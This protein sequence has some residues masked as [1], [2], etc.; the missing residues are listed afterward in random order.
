VRTAAVVVAA[1]AGF[2]AT[3]A[4][5]APVAS[6]PDDA[7]LGSL[8]FARAGQLHVVSLATCDDVT[9]GRAPTARTASA[10]VSP[11]GRF[12][13][14]VRAT[15]H[16]RTA[17]QTIWVTDRRMRRSHPVTSETEYYRTIGPGD[18]PGPLWLFGFSPD[19]RWILFTVDPGGSASIAADGTILRVV[20]ARGGRVHKLGVALDYADYH[21][22]CGRNLVFTGG[23]DRVAT[24]RKRL[25][26]A[27][28]PAWRPRNLWPDPRESFGS[29]ACSPDGRSV[30]VLAQHSSQDAAFFSTRWRL[31]RVRLDGK[32]SLLDAPPPGFADESP[33][34]SRD[35]RSLL[36]VREQEGFG[37]AMLLRGGALYGPVAKLGFSIG[38]YGHHDWGVRW[39]E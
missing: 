35:G 24:D 33:Q 5:R 37:T 18:T 1:L 29:V 19:D 2:A 23:F 36:F 8:R 31:W 25:L 32:R 26:V 28:P 11:D 6:C 15:G 17:R 34:W 9:A 7:A 12:V 21:T 22:W 14:R 3:A 13:A 20:A 39:S 10:V 30:A 16:G 38:Y 27:S 4:G